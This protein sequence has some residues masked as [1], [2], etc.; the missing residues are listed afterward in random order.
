MMFNFSTNPEQADTLLASALNL[1]RDIASNGITTE[2]F[3]RAQNNLQK[4]HADYRKA[5][6]FWLS[7]ISER[8]R[9]DSSDMLEYEKA[10]KQV[11]PAD[12]KKLARL[13]SK[14]TN[15]VEVI[16]DGI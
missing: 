8:V 11:K 6:A 13:L 12:V 9:H 7:A 5:N 16:M 2:E 1:L 3:A 10:L 14:S 4:Q 15:T